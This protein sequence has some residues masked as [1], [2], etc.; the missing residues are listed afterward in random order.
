MA[1]AEAHD[2]HFPLPIYIGRR[3]YW[4]EEDLEAF[5]RGLLGQPNPFKR[6]PETGNAGG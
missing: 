4:L 1:L 5:E 6:D 2:L 3:P